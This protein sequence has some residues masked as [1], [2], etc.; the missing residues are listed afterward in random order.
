MSTPCPVL[1]VIVNYKTAAYTIQ[2]LRT[3]EPEVR[4]LPGARVALVENCSG[5]GD[6][7]ARAIADN[8]WSEWVSLDVAD[9]NG[10]FAYGNNR[11]IR[12]TLS[13]PDPPRYVL[14]LNSD[15]EVRAGAIRALVRFMDARPEVGIAGSS[16]ENLDGTDW[17]FAFRFIRPLSELDRGLKFGPVSRLLKRYVPA[18]LMDQTR[19]QQVDWVAGASMIIRH[20]VFEK[21]GL[22]DEDYFLYFEEVDFCLR[23]ARQGIAC[24]YVPESRIM[25]IA[26]QSSALT[27]RDA[28]PP[29]TPAY[30]FASRRRY[31]RKNY[32]LAG[33]VVADLAF[34]F[35]HSLWR[36]RRAIFRKPD[37]DP[38]HSLTDHW[39]NSVFLNRNR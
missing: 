34:G 2:C 22:L 9:R 1:V 4:D 36:V 35:G 11:A 10:G 3:L 30:W 13:A 32:G 39:R 5:D 23:A 12:P 19:P 15:T 31:F 16:F 29:R 38:P 24:W 7:L 18:R 14:L 28:R 17:P 21:I 25:H 33:A 20:T 6:V 8:G 26:G 37:T 27:K